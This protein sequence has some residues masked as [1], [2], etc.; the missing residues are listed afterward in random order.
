MPIGFP[1]RD[2][3]E[4]ESLPH[5]SL[6]FQIVVFSVCCVFFV[7]SSWERKKEQK[8]NKFYYRELKYSEL[9][10]CYVKIFLTVP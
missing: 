8:S 1:T 10:F 2:E 7:A 4:K 9:F 5:I 6:G 3:N